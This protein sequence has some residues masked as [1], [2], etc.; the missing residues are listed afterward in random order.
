MRRFALPLS[1]VVLTCLA[2]S[3]QSGAAVYWGNISTIGVANLDGTSPIFDFS[4]G[5]AATPVCG[6]AVNENEL[7]WAETWS[8]GRINLNDG[9]AQQHLIS[10]LL[11]PCA[12]AVDGLHVYWGSRERDGISR[13]N[14]D[15]SDANPAFISGGEISPRSLAV[16]GGR[17]Y[18]SERWGGISR[19][20]LDGTEIDRGFVE[21][22]F[23]TGL[24]VD[25]RHIYWGENEGIGRANLD[26]SEV[27]KGLIPNTGGAENIAT[28]GSRLYWT[29]TDS[30]T[31]SGIVG[32]ASVDGTAV[33]PRL[34]ST[35]LPSMYGIALDS[36]PAA[37]LPSQPSMPLF[38]VKLSREKRKGVVYLAIEAPVRGEMKVTSP[39]L[40]WKVVKSPELPPWVGGYARWKLKLWSGHASS[41]TSKRIRGQLKRTGRAPLNLQIS[42]QEEGKFPV[43]AEKKLVLLKST[44]SDRSGG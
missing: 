15:G 33:N 41:A 13:A 3:S 24:A 2:W 36:R 12:I 23:A 4:P 10:G 35:P 37:L 40:G 16:R 21:G 25:D 19:A 26:G 7:F 1:V 29:R 43:L 22:A 31:L 42:F 11:Q 18:W 14:L 32:V 5:L 28:D 20:N 9:T 6:L 27:E 34:I 38:F 8:I 39:A 44:R 30:A 17:I